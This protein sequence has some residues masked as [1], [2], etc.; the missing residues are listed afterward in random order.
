M[1]R[2]WGDPVRL[3]TDTEL[4]FPETAVAIAVLETGHFHSRSMMKHHNY[5]GF[6]GNRRGFQI[7][8]QRGYGVYATGAAMMADYQA[9]EQEIC[10]RHGLTTE[11]AFRRWIYRHYAEDP[12]YATK[13]AT[14]I[15]EVVLTWR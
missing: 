12:H 1:V 6:R 13:L 7:R 11:A 14:A 10:A 4:L 3:I 2:R 9:W 5:F 8:V 15:S